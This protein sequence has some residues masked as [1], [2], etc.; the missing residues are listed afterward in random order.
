MFVLPRW[1]D[2]RA[3]GLIGVALIVSCTGNR[4]EREADEIETA[5][6]F[7]P[8]IANAAS[9]PGSAPDGMVWIPG[10]EFSM[11]AEDP[12]GNASS[13]LDPMND[14][15]PIHRVYVEGFWMDRTEV[16]NAEFDRFVRATHYVTVA[17]RVPRA[18]DFPSAPREN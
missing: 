16:T 3:A 8:T 12:R 14:A 2:R 15:R 6:R 18:D 13:S 10:G 7:R 9:P 11:G 1:L 4:R 5:T 17:E